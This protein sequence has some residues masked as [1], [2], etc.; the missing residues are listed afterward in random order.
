VIV[1]LAGEQG[2]NC[3]LSVPGETVIENGVKILAPLNVPSTLAEH[4]S[5][6][7]AKNIQALLGLMIGAPTEGPDGQTLVGQLKLDFEDEV[8]AGACI[9]RD[10]EIVHDGAKQAAAAAA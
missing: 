4:A 3:E 7:Y 9:T 2:G 1:D 10:G 5:Q 8:I 6:L